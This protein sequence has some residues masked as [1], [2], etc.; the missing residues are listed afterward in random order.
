MDGG[1]LV[2]PVAGHVE[3]LV[4]VGVKLVVLEVGGEAV[5]LPGDVLVTDLAGVLD[6]AVDGDVEPLVRPDT[7]VG[8]EI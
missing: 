8:Y 7:T 5:R 2:E 4:L 3:G 6:I 1:G